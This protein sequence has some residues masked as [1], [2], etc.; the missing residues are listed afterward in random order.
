MIGV[1]FPKW[2]LERLH[3][4]ATDSIKRAGGID[5]KRALATPFVSAEVCERGLCRQQYVQGD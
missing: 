4:R 3:R 1:A 2:S 5:D